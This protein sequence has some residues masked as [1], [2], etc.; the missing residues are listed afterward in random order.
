[1]SGID[2]RQLLA[3]VIRPTLVVLGS[4]FGGQAWEELLLGTQLQESSGG[5]Y[6]HQ[7]GNGPAAGIWEME[8]G[9]HDDIW[10]N[11][12]KYKPDLAAKVKSIMIGAVS[13]FEEM[14]GNLYYAC[15]MAAL[16]Y[17][18]ATIQHKVNLA[19]AGDLA[20]QAAFY[21]QFYNTPAGAAT[22]G[23]Y[24]SNWNAAMGGQPAA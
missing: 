5:R 14:E 8:K 11:F 19:A 3:L 18:R 4:P 7:L 9:D 15:A 13:D 16:H 17:L 12:L 21:K 24:I 6:L 23:Q 1:M 20:G 10:S 2:P 22:T